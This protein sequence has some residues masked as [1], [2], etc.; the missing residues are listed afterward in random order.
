M[1]EGIYVVHKKAKCEE[2]KEKKKKEEEK[3]QE[4]F[5]F[6]K[7]GT[8]RKKEIRLTVGRGWWNEGKRTVD[9]SGHV[10]KTYEGGNHPK[11]KWCRGQGGGGKTQY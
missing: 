9:S 4:H 5:G 6:E 1:G 7:R 2:L 10:S 11:K 3:P 8:W